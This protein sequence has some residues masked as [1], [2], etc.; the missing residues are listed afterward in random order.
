MRRQTVCGR[1]APSSLSPLASGPAR[2]ELGL[3]LPHVPPP[4][5]LDDEGDAF[6]HGA[7]P[8]RGLVGGGVEVRECPLPF[9]LKQPEQRPFDVVLGGA[10]AV[11]PLAFFGAGA[12]GGGLGWGGGGGGVGRGARAPTALPPPPL[13]PT[14][15]ATAPAATMGAR[16]RTPERGS[17]MSR[18]RGADPGAT[19]PGL[20]P[21]PATRARAMAATEAG[22]PP[23]AVMAGV[24]SNRAS[25]RPAT[26][27]RLPSP[28]A[29]NTRAPAAGEGRNV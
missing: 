20:P 21:V 12:G 4:P 10:R 1:Q 3:G 2:P 23:P 19:A 16:R 13:F 11:F 28:P 7:Q 17:S 25:T 18:A 6:E 8:G 24:A 14:F 29:S 15:L 27:G 26:A 5:P 9:R 22:T